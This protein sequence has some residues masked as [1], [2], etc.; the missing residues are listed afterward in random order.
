[1]KRQLPTQGVGT[2]CVQKKRLSQQKEPVAVDRIF[3]KESI[4]SSITAECQQ[5]ISKDITFVDFS[6]GDNVFSS[7]L[8]C[9]FVAYDVFPA[10]NAIQQD[11]FTVSELPSKVIIG[12]NPPFGY[13]GSLAKK[14][15]EHSLQFKPEYFFLIL[16]SMKWFPCGYEE[17]FSM[18]LPEDS[19]YDP[20]NGKS[21]KEICTT[22][23]IW[24]RS[25]VQDLPREKIP[26]KH[27]PGIFVTRKWL[28]LRYPRIILRRVGR[29][30]TKQ[31][32][33][34]TDKKNTSYFESGKV[35]E[36]I[37]P[38]QR[39]HA[40]ESEYFLKIYF[41]TE[42]Q[43]EDLLSFCRSVYENPEEGF[44]RKQPHA[45]SNPYVYTMLEKWIHG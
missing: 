39:K 7:M 30:T 11:W 36:D 44:D 31:F 15:I 18:D 32:Y 2:G 42:K 37:T 40:V 21:L 6:C 20:S 16:P 14:F 22:F 4:L 23:H 25:Q 27:L 43:M 34:S 24:K 9:D 13:Q 19:F 10:K 29:N 45:I 26:R 41:D 8:F 17:I 1:M 33:C 38:K 12:L 35:H 5:Y 28:T 3:T